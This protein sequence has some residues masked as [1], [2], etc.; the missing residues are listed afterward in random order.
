MN[1]VTRSKSL[2]TQEMFMNNEKLNSISQSARDK[3][4]GVSLHYFSQ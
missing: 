1:F 2:H 4:L 3:Q